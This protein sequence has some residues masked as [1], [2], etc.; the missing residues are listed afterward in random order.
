MTTATLNDFSLDMSCLEH[1]PAL[2]K[3]AMDIIR[4]IAEGVSWRQLNGHKL[5]QVDVVSV[6]VGNRY[7]ILF[8]CQGMQPMLVLTHEAYN[9]V[10]SNVNRLKVLL[11]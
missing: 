9:K 6:P 11:K 5:L 10:V 1:V 7:R 8:N 4:K 3:K 2:L